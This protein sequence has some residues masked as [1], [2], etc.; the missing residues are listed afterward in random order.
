MSGLPA[1]LGRVNAVVL[2]TCESFPQS[3]RGWA[4]AES[5]PSRQAVGVR[6]VRQ[7]QPRSGAPVCHR[8]PCAPAATFPR[9]CRPPARVAY[10]HVPSLPQPESN[11][12]SGLVT[13]EGYFEQGEWRE[14]DNSASLRSLGGFH[15]PGRGGGAWVTGP[16]LL[17]LLPR[18]CC[19]VGPRN[20]MSGR[21]K[22]HSG[23]QGVPEPLL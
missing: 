17:C 10:V 13:G 18:R 21:R 16:P 5:A 15:R 20:G 19:P 2:S 6:R 3:C 4:Q 7:E 1:R 12:Q 11:R 14:P 8:W 9:L 23:S 22:E